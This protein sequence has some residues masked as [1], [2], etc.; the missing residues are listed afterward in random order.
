MARTRSQAD[1]VADV[2]KRADIENVTDRFPDAEIEEYIN[3]SIARLYMML[4]RCDNTYYVTTQSINT[5]AGTKTY[6]LAAGFTS[7]KKVSA[8]VG[9]S[10]KLPVRKYNIH[11]DDW[12]ELVGVW[13]S[14]LVVK[15]RLRGS[16]ISFSPTPAGV[17]TV[18][19]EYLTAPVRLSGATPFDG[20]AGFEEWVVLDAAIKVRRKQARDASDLMMDKSE[21]EQ[22]IQSTAPGRDQNEPE[23]VADTSLVDRSWL[24]TVT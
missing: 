7:I 20:I 14:D 8:T 10:K 18:T 24:Y 16:D 5:V 19:I 23:C 13:S 9:G 1:L 4:D 21:V 17:Y 2:R 22:W 11:E 6:A 12:L 15:Y 3:Q